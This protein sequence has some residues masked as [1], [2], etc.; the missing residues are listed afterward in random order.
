MAR[1]SM[2]GRWLHARAECNGRLRWPGERS[3]FRT[4]PVTVFRA[5]P[6]ARRR[7]SRPCQRRQLRDRAV[8]A[9]SDR[10][11]LWQQ[12]RPHEPGR[13]EL[14]HRPA[15]HRGWRGRRSPS[16]ASARPCC[17]A[18][19]QVGAIVPFEVAGRTQ[20]AVR[21]TYNGRTSPVIQMPVSP[22]APGV[23][24][25]AANGNGQAS[26]LNQTGAINAPALPPRGARS[27][28]ST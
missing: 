11:D 23:F 8:G 20:V 28:R 26:I 7:S 2:P 5:G 12:S 25:T 15:W 3:P 18:N 21:V 6:L 1:M 14:Y 9:W 16:T 4:I 22:D 24:T 10:R 13:P 27:S 19:T 17:T